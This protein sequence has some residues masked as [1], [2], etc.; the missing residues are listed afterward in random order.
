[1]VKVFMGHRISDDQQPKVGPYGYLNVSQNCLIDILKAHTNFHGL[2]LR[3]FNNPQKHEKNCLLLTF[4]D[5]YKDFIDNALPI[6]EKFQTPSILFLSTGFID[7]EI[8]PFEW[9]LADI[10][11]AVKRLKTPDLKTH[12]VTDS[13]RQQE[14]YETIRQT[15]KNKNNAS[16][17]A[18]LKQ[19]RSINHTAPKPRTHTDFLNWQEI[20]ALDQHSLI[21][22]GAHTRTH[23]FLPA[24]SLLEAY[25]EIRL[26]KIRIEKI[27][28]HSIDCFSYPYGGHSPIIRLLTRFAGF[29]YAFTTDPKP[30]NLSACNRFSIPRLDL[31]NHITEN[32]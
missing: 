9:E 7:G 13:T 23:P 12:T 28:R 27:L 31:H 2:N 17:Q 14:I 19:L 4:D 32:N 15:L 11:T 6:I 3:S 24:I 16:R 10:I 30:M 20:I 21:T 18:Y 29:K 1:M 5:G 22:I 26:S 25:Y 8:I